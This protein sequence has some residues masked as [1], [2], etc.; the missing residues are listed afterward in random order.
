MAV[1]MRGP[2]V[3]MKPGVGEKLPEKSIIIAA[4]L[5]DIC[6]ANIYKKAK[7]WNLGNGWKLTTWPRISWNNN[8]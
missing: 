6:K 1:A 3:A 2:I 8:I 5:H 4:L 7:K